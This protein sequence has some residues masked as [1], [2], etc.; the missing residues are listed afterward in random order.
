MNFLN[1][2]E[3]KFGHIGIRGLMNYIIGLNILV[4]ILVYTDPSGAFF[5]KLVLNPQLVLQGEV[6][7][8]ITFIFIPPTFSIFWLVFV[9][10]FYY[11]IG[12]SLEREWGVF[13]FNVYYFIGILATI[14]GA[15]LTGGAATSLYLNLALLLAFACIFPNY[16]ILV[17][18]V[19]PVKIKYLAWLD[20]AFLAFHMIIGSFAMRVM[21]IASI[22]N[23]LL[24]FWRD[25]YNWVR[26]G[27][28]AFYKKQ[29]YRAKADTPRG[30]VISV[31]RCEVCGRS[32]WDDKSL[33]FRY[34]VDC[35]GDHEYCMEHLA[36][37]VHVKDH[38]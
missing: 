38:N 36:N 26:S 22:F 13:K 25:L 4:F 29:A 30:R 12:S 10:Y 23:F 27:S 16:Q 19:L 2:L 33:E 32:E 20:A 11:M 24:F 5:N 35:D 6:W 14:A 28:R 37:H 7:R 31:H 9:L 1:K 18:F 21:I 8:I 3:R 17:F 34:C 15:F